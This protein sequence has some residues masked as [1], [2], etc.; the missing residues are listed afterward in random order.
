M[1]CCDLLAQEKRSYN[2]KTIVLCAGTIESAKIALQSKL[3]DPAG[4]IGQGI[5]DHMIRYR[6][7]TVPPGNPQSSTTDSAKILLQH[8]NATVDQHAFDIVVELGADFNQ[9]RYI[10]PNNLAQERKEHNGWMLCEIVF[11][12]YKAEVP[13][14]ILE[15]TELMKSSSIP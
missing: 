5:T 9:G 14:V 8:P 13:G 3:A 4:L 15:R 2:G 6:H 7:F 10:D 11:Q 12:Y 1:Q